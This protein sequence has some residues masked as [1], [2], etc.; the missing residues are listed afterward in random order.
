[1]TVVCVYIHPGAFLG[2][3][4]V[5]KVHVWSI[6][7]TIHGVELE[8]LPILGIFIHRYDIQLFYIQVDI[9]FIYDSFL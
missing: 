3:Q 2:P 8:R 4:K 5:Q 7:R 1:M 9:C 6:S